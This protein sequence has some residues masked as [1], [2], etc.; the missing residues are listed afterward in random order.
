M[1]DRSDEVNI[2][3]HILLI[4]NKTILIMIWNNDTEKRKIKLTL[5]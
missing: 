4:A 3:V 5:Q 1:G 2:E